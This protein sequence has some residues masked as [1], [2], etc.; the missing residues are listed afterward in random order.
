MLKKLLIHCTL[1]EHCK[2]LNKHLSTVIADITELDG[3]HAV[4]FP[5]LLQG[6]HCAPLLRAG[7]PLQNVIQVHPVMVASCAASNVDKHQ[8]N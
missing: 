1:I 3:A 6:A 4:V 8:K 2:S 7:V 5:G